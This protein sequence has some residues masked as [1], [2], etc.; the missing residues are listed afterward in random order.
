MVKYMVLQAQN[1]V[2]IHLESIAWELL[3]FLVAEGFQPVTIE[4]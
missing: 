2:I 1:R 4:S 3:T